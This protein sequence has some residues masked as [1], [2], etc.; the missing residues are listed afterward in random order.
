M[1]DQYQ[2]PQPLVQTRDL[3]KYYPIRGGV[4]LKEIASVKAVDHVSLTIGNGE[5]RQPLAGRF[6][7]WKNPHPVKY[8][9]KV[10]TFSPTLQ[11]RCGPCVKQFK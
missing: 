1:S 11:Y 10:K 7:G 8:S 5:E 3:V 2:E 9:L 6:S 4:F